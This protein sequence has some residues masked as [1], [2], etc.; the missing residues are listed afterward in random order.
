MGFSGYMNL[1]PLLLNSVHTLKSASL[2]F[3]DKSRHHLG[4]ETIQTIVE[5]GGYSETILETAKKMH[6]DVIVM[7]S[8]SQKWLENIL[9]GSVTQ[10][11]LHHTTIPLFIVPTKKHN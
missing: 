10:E 3:L 6:A 7:G 5:E 11:V 8:H 9:L 2:D 4:D 1:D